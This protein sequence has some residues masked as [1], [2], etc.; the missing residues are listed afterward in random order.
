MHTVYK[1]SQS[2]A[3][4]Q[5]GCVLLRTVV[6]CACESKEC[7]GQMRFVSHFSKP[8][9]HCQPFFFLRMKFIL[10]LG[11]PSQLKLSYLN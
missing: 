10:F 1:L 7:L 5:Q 4:E 3:T 8:L 2:R 9:L 6:Y 11:L